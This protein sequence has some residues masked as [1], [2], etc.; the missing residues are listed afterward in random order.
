MNGAVGIY[1]PHVA[2]SCWDIYTHIH[3]WPC[4]SV[5][6]ATGVV[7]TTSVTHATPA[8]AYAS[9]VS[10]LYEADH[11]VPP[12]WADL[13][14]DIARQLIERGHKINVG[15]AY[16]TSSI[17]RVSSRGVPFL[18]FWNHC[19][20]SIKIHFAIGAYI[21]LVNRMVRYAAKLIALRMLISVHIMKVFFFC[22][23]VVL[24]GGRA[25]FLGYNHS[26]PVENTQ[27]GNRLDNRHLINVG[28][29]PK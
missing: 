5:G 15:I 8:A 28:L 21:L 29:M 20:L 9:S 2:G 7:T 11:L 26:D 3:I 1:V 24:G 17:W 16:D 12:I 10:R 19:A 13:C 4:V 14:P 22:T 27:K 18:F 6:K 23:K 25:N